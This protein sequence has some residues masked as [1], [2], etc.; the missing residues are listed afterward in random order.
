MTKKVNLVFHVG[1]GKTA[2]SAVQSKMANLPNVLFL[3]KGISADRKVFNNEINDLHYKLFKTFRMEAIMGFANPSRSSTAL[4]TKYAEAIVRLTSASRKEIVVLSDE[5]IGDYLNYIGEWNVFLTIALGNM[6]EEKL[7]AKGYEVKKNLSFTIRRQLDV[8]KSVIG[9]QPTMTIRSVDELLD[10][11]SDNHEEGI[12]GSY[13]YYS[14]IRLFESITG[15]EFIGSS[16]DLVTL[17]ERYPPNQHQRVKPTDLFWLDP[18]L[19]RWRQILQ[20]NQ[21]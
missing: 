15:V 20:L 12:Q 5:C 2:T 14:N 9:Y 6:V 21:A 3:G 1:Y 19:S 13:Y 17:L 16:R 18:E 4:L 10:F 11:F 7:K 8:L